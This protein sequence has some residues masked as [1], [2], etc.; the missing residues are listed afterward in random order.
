MELLSSLES[1]DF[2]NIVK[3]PKLKIPIFTSYLPIQMEGF[4]QNKK[5]ISG[6]VSEK[7]QTVV[8]TFIA[9]LVNSLYICT[10]VAIVLFIGMLVSNDMINLPTPMRIFGFLVACILSLTPPGMFLF[11]IYYGLRVFYAISMN[12]ILDIKNPE[13]IPY[14]P[15]IFALLPIYNGRIES[16]FLGALMYPFTYPKSDSAQEKLKELVEKYKDNLDKSFGSLDEYLKLIDGAQESY[17]NAIAAIFGRHGI[18][19]VV[20]SKP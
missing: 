9:A 2:K 4:F 6:V 13:K 5:D 17:D 8:E 14:F 12:Y 18:K 10:Y 20:E 16:S 3:F 19:K 7:Q 11:M 15:K 1:I